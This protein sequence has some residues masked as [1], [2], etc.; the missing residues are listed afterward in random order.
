MTAGYNDFFPQLVV[1]FALVLTTSVRLSNEHIGLFV[2]NL[3][4][5]HCD[6]QL[7]E[8]CEVCSIL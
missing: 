5:K 8:A 7:S 4:R 1:H 6:S 3:A 2:Y